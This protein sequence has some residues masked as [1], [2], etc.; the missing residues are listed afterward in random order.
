[1]ESFLC[2]KIQNEGVFPFFFLNKWYTFSLY[3]HEWLM[4]DERPG[5]IPIVINVPRLSILIF[6]KDVLSF[7]SLLN[8]NGINKTYALKSA[9]VQAPRRKCNRF[10]K[11]WANLRDV[12]AKC[13][14]NGR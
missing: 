3:V 1:M 6:I 5:V 14:A 4:W 10:S 11:G 9:A 8:S 2:G 13:G 12:S 7:H